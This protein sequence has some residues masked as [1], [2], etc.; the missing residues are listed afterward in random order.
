[1]RSLFILLVLSLLS[2]SAQG[3][4]TP[5]SPPATSGLRQAIESS[6]KSEARIQVGGAPGARI[7]SNFPYG[8]ESLSGWNGKIGPADTVPSGG[9][10]DPLITTPSY[11]GYAKAYVDDGKTTYLI[12]GLRYAPIG[13]TPLDLNNINNTFVGVGKNFDNGVIGEVHFGR[14]KRQLGAECPADDCTAN[15]ATNKD[16]MMFYFGKAW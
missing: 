2:P 7:G 1:M 3:E 13:P 15:A 4:D 16:G 11:G 9:Q 5:A 10:Y 12:G 14:I 6:E 8:L